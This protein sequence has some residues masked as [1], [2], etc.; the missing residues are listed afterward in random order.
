[1]LSTAGQAIA[2]RLGIRPTLDYQPATRPRLTRT[3]VF[4]GVNRTAGYAVA[5]Y[6]SSLVAGEHAH[7]IAVG[8]R[9]GATLGV[10]TVI[11]GSFVPFVEW[12]ADHVPARRMGVFG[13]GL[14]LAGFALQSLQYWVAFLDVGVQ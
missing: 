14:I 6:V 7:A 12:E 2:Y 1:M 8:L 5:G 9:T 10:V 3:Q 13:V 4:A 11:A